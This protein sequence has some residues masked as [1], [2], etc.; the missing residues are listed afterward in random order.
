MQMSYLRFG[1]MVATSTVVMF[2]LMYLNTF[3]WD[4]VRWSETRVYMALL[5]GST[6]GLIML[7]FMLS[8]YRSTRLN[9]GIAAGRSCSS[10]SRSS[11]SAARPP[12]RTLPT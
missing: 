3:A 2:I 7:G 11:S 9:I 10:H 8:M 12:C 4:H 6:M 5:M 1:A